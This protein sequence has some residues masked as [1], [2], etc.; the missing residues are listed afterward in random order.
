MREM[1]TGKPMAFWAPW[2]TSNTEGNAL[3]A[4]QFSPAA[5]AI[6]RGKL[7]SSSVQKARL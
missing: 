7:L 2:A 5:K 3:N 6:S 1:F 4:A